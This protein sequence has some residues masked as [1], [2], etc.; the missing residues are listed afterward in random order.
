MIDT[1]E[2]SVEISLL[3]QQRPEVRVF[4]EEISKADGKLIPLKKL[5]LMVKNYILLQETLLTQ[6]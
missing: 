2:T 4:V 3:D 1:P 5:R 6:S